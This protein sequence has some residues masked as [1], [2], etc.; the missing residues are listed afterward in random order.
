MDDRFNMILM[1]QEVIDSGGIYYIPDSFVNY[2]NDGNHYNDSINRPPNTAVG[3]TIANAI[4][5]ASDHIPIFAEFSFNPQT[6]PTTFQLAVSI[7]NGWNMVSV[8]G[9]NPV[10][11]EVN[12]WWSEKDPAA[13]VYK[14]TGSYQSITVATPGE[15]YWM[16]HLGANVYNTGD[17]WPV[18]GIEIVAHDPITADVGWNLIGGYENTVATSSLTTTPPGL[19]AGPIYK[20]SDG[21]QVASNLAAGYGYWIKL[22]GTGVINI[23]ATLA[24]RNGEVV[25]YFKED[26]GKIMITDAAGR[27]YTLYAVNG[28]VELDQYELPPMPPAGM[29]DIRFGSGGI[30]EDLNGV[31][32][33]LEMRGIE[34]PLTVRVENMDIRLQDE[35]GK[36]INE[37]LKSGEDIVI[38]DATIQKLM[39]TGELVPA[40]YVLEQNYPNPFNPSTIIEFSLP[41]NV[42]N[43]KLSIYNTL[44]E[45]VAELVNKALTAGK[46]QYQWNAGNAATGMYIYELRTDKF[47]SVKKMVLLK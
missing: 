17:E 11:Q 15:G 33:M 25:E 10:G 20:Y 18:G 8:P 37:R 30:A 39:V 26:W 3:Q 4:H 47:V 9:V 14:Y 16:K 44:G 41:E 12:T 5:Y 40:A 21:Y 2:G 19:I 34:Y 7:D 46:Y 1:S 24:R 27:S 23:P 28:E 31:M 29:F 22:S 36:S 45:K 43:V 35:T 6:N 38:S 13:N 42:G 32:Q